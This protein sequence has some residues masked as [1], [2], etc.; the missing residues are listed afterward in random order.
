MLQRLL[1]ASEPV[2]PPASTPEE[3][4][5]PPPAHAPKEKQEPCISRAAA[6][7]YEDA[8]VEAGFSDWHEWNTAYIHGMIRIDGKQSKSMTKYPPCGPCG[9]ASKFAV[10]VGL[11]DDDPYQDFLLGEKKVCCGWCE[12][13]KMHGEEDRQQEEKYSRPT[14]PASCQE[15]KPQQNPAQGGD[16]DGHE[17]GRQPTRQSEFFINGAGLDPEVVQN[18]IPLWLGIDSLVRPGTHYVSSVPVQLGRTEC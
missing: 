17:P 4:Y 5:E 14:A 15:R 10:C 9:E 6:D 16:M 18:D 13:E 3:V 1:S 8:R 11:M 7:I 12:Y 2:S